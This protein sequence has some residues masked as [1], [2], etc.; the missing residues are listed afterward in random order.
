M[1]KKVGD[2]E[3]VYNESEA[4]LFREMQGD[5]PWVLDIEGYIDYLFYETDKSAMRAYENYLKTGRIS[6]ELEE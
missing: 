6:D 3:Y 2:F 5:I 4:F 1:W